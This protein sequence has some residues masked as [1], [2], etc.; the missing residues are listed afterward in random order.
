MIE[1]KK[2]CV[3]ARSNIEITRGK[4]F[5]SRLTLCA[6]LAKPAALLVGGFNLLHFN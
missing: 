3:K 1:T 5:K 6:S 4:R 2:C